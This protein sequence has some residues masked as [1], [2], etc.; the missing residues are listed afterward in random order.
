[1]S[2]VK[3]R[4]DF[5]ASI[6]KKVSTSAKDLITKLLTKDPKARIDVVQALDHKWFG[7]HH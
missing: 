6:W 4:L 3:G 1:M 2:I 7:E 5:K